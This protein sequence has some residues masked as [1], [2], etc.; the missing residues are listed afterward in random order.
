MK[1]FS[2]GGILPI[3]GAALSVTAGAATIFTGT[4]PVSAAIPDADDVGISDT[5]N[6]SAAGLTN[7]QLVTVTL[8]LTGGWN[9]DL[10]GYLV[11]S[12]GFSVLLN[13]PGRD[14]ATP[15]GSASSGMSV[16][17]ADAAATDIHTAIPMSGG[18]VS[19]TYQPDGR[20]AD[21]LVV[22]SSSPRTALLSS[23][24][25]LDANGSW[26]LFLADQSPGDVSTLSSWTLNIQG[27]PEP[28]STSLA[29]AV[30]LHFLARRRRDHIV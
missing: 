5:R 24:D 13:R 19:G 16:T 27:I 18:P 11:H 2:I 26:T 29:A 30:S 7:I 14:I 22:L 15:D 25:G 10:Y 6:V 4:F 20:T 3:A 17:L 21:P 9:G 1:H 8:N 23:F 12:T 28:T